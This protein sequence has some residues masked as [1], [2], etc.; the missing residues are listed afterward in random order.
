MSK[1][2][3]EQEISISGLYDFDVNEDRVIFGWIN[4]LTTFTLLNLETLTLTHF[5]IGSHIQS[6]V[7]YMNIDSNHIYIGT[8]SNFVVVDYINN[9]HHSVFYRDKNFNSFAYSFDKMKLVF[10]CNDTLNIW[11]LNTYNHTLLRQYKLYKSYDVHY[12]SMKLH[13][14]FISIEYDDNEIHI[15]NIVTFDSAV[16]RHENYHCFTMSRDEEVM[17]TCNDVNIFVWDTYLK[18]KRLIIPINNFIDIGVDVEDIRIQRIINCCTISD[19][20]TTILCRTHSK[21]L[22]FE[23]TMQFQSNFPVQPTPR[24]SKQYVV[25]TLPKCISCKFYSSDRFFMTYYYDQ[26][27]KFYFHDKFF[28]I[29]KNIIEKEMSLASSS[30]S[31]LPMELLSL[32]YEFI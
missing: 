14:K 1:T 8:T 19:D 3:C 23:D 12:D 30:F 26:K 13:G 18:W 2:S 27:I 5:D 4:N 29:N 17:I 25:Q 21:C 31:K 7:I 16:C 10:I 15:I 20:K 9:K 11:H 32:I 22:I 6:D 24:T 28:N